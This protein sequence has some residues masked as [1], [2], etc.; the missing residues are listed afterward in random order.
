MGWK[1]GNRLRLVSEDD[2]PP[3]TREIF[4]EICHSLGLPSVPILYQAYAAFPQFLELHWR[5]FR[6]A[7]QSRQFFMLGAR[8]AAES[9]TRAHNYFEIAALTMYESHP[10][11][12]PKLPI[13]QVLDYYQYLD[14]LLL[15]ISAAQ[16]QA[17]EGPVGEN[18]NFEPANHPD[19][20]VPPCLLNLE[21]VS[22][23][24]QRTWDE[25][26]RILDVAVVS[27]E[28]RALACWP[29]F[30][31]EY[32]AVLKSILRSPVY[33]DCQYRIGESALCLVAELPVQVETGVAQLLDAGMDGEELCSL[34]RINEAFMQAMTG[35]VLDVTFAR[36]GCEGGTHGQSAA[37][38]ESAR[39][40]KKK[41]KAGSPT[42]A[43]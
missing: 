29:D 21:Q 13:S 4:E 5:A 23:A 40:P 14:P 6:P 3:R 22:P 41:K 19:F 27:D 16:M 28:H 17:F 15:L 7:L 12:S 25:R 1:R 35:L 18:G 32:W 30:Y 31:R 37:Q 38:R 11:V 9:Y 8:M 24:V 33:A 10:D 20:P 39:A 42:R 2:A 34:V 43:A 36:I 26:R